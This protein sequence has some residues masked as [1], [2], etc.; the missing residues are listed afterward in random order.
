MSRRRQQ[1]KPKVDNHVD[2]PIVLPEWA[3][4]IGDY[5][6]YLFEM[7]SKTNLQF[8]CGKII[9]IKSANEDNVEYVIRFEDEHVCQVTFVFTEKE[10]QWRLG[11]E[12]EFNQQK[13][14]Y[15]NKNSMQRDDVVE[16]PTLDDSEIRRILKQQLDEFKKDMDKMVD[17]KIETGKPSKELVGDFSH[18]AIEAWAYATSEYKKKHL[19]KEKLVGNV[20]PKGGK[21]GQSSSTSRMMCNNYKN[22]IQK[23]TSKE[24]RDNIFI[25][26]DAKYAH[27]TQLAK[28]ELRQNSVKNAISFL[29]MKSICTQCAKSLGSI[30]SFTNTKDKVNTCCICI[31]KLKSKSGSTSAQGV[32]LCNDCHK[33]S[34]QTQEKVEQFLECAIKPFAIMFQASYVV[35]ET[36]PNS[37]LAPDLVITLKIK[38][39]TY[40]IILEMDQNQHK[41]GSYTP[42]KEN[43]KM[44]KQIINMI[45][46]VEPQRVKVFAIRF[47]PNSEWIGLDNIKST[48]YCFAE[49]II[50]LRQWLIWYVLNADYVRDL[51][52]MYLWYDAPNKNKFLFPK[53]DG[54][55]MQYHAPKPNLIDWQYN[56]T[57]WEFENEKLKTM[58]DNKQPVTF[59]W[60]IDIQKEK[61]PNEIYGKLA[62]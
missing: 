58:N 13:R 2:I 15:I 43:D 25:S 12:E 47:N 10:K 6:W 34:T 46:S 17:D 4:K 50:I 48:L 21:D 49:R 37:N 55:T 3:P 32:F 1:K 35:N 51:I 20:S 59:P 54:F 26:A 56:I 31:S 29:K 5:A 7:G 42:A 19:G 53:F 9:D 11:T 52:I 60:N 18:N 16:K 45:K 23:C 33:S 57:P 44:M 8:F 14:L 30:D 36:T 61:Y 28:H 24:L 62:D 22:L 41:G 27:L 38:G 40:K 39:I